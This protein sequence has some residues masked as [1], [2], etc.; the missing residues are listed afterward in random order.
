[1]RLARVI[2]TVVATEKHPDFDGHKLLVCQP[3]DEL[4]GADGTSMIAIDLVQ[5][6]VGDHVLVLREGNSVRQLIRQDKAC[7]RSAIVGIVDAVDVP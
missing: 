7:I 3:L 6:G 1:M 4:G 5:A 2:G